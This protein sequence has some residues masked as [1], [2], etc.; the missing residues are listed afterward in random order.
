MRVVLEAIYSALGLAVIAVCDVHPFPHI[1]DFGCGSDRIYYDL[2][3]RLSRFLCVGHNGSPS[4]LYCESAFF[5]PPASR[6]IGASHLFAN[7]GI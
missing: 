2:L 6:R 3:F 7:V 5:A 4:G 1:L